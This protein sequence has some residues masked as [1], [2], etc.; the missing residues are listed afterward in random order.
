MPRHTLVS[1][2]AGILAVMLLTMEP[3]LCS[4]PPSLLGRPPRFCKWTIT[5][6]AFIA[7]L[8]KQTEPLPAP[9][10][11]VTTV[12]RAGDTLYQTV[13]SGERRQ[14]SW[15]VGSLQYNL[16]VAG[17]GFFSPTSSEES[18]HVPMESDS[19]LE[20]SWISPEFSIG[21]MTVGGRECLVYVDVQGRKIPQEAKLEN[22][23]APMLAAVPAG[24]K[25]VPGIL[26]QTVLAEGVRIACLDAQ[27]HLPYLLQ[28]GFQIRSY[29]FTPLPAQTLPLPKAL[30]EMKE[31]VLRAN[32]AFYAAPARP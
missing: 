3:L 6:V 15:R 19:F 14:E 32:R 12:M 31:A 24:G 28:N 2:T 13:Q 5:T 22:L 8:A 26:P 18:A 9:N 20:F 16:P 11:S 27:T 7:P 17:D 30:A 25:N 23:F 21:S 4:T 10:R 29:E 1:Y